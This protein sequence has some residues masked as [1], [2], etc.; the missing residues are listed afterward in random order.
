M[1]KALQRQ[2]NLTG[3]FSDGMSAGQSES[4]IGR[5]SKLSQVSNPIKSP[6]KKKI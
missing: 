1:I 3:L 5:Q 2:S 6:K 4:M